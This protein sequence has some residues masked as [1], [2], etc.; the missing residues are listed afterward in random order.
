MIKYLITPSLINSFEYYI[1]DEWKTPEDSRADFLKT[2]SRERFKPNEAMQK[3]I[4]FEDDINKVCQN[5]YLFYDFG[6][7]DENE[8]GLE[9]I[10]QY[11]E[12]ISNIAKIVKNGLWQESCKKDMNFGNFDIILY[13]RCD[14]IKADTIYDIK[15]TGNYD[16]GKF[17]N[18]I[19]HLIYMYCLDLPKFAYLISNGKDWW[20]EDYIN[21]SKIEDNI[22]SKVNNFFEYLKTDKE[23]KRIFHNNW[24]SKY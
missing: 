18:S 17:Q 20:R 3:G 6:C 10:L 16:I 1:G 22:R 15:Y 8:K 2:L 11:E 12:I 7:K 24:K 23:A 13:G 14:V 9:K 5:K 4:D 21:C 19:Q